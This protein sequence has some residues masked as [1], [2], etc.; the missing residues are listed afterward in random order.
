MSFLLCTD[1]SHWSC[2]HLQALEYDPVYWP[3]LESLENVKSLAVDRW[4]YRML[5]HS[6]R[7]EAYSRAI[8]RAVAAAAASCAGQSAVRFQNE[9]RPWV[10]GRLAPCGSHFYHLTKSYLRK[11]LGYPP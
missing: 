10:G 7:N 1:L 2:P 9:T 5:N 6:A 8:K 4:H 11:T 3:A